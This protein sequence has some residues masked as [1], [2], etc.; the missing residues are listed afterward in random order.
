MEL[1]TFAKT[2]DGAEGSQAVEKFSCRPVGDT[3]GAAGKTQAGFTVS[4]AALPGTFCLRW[5][6][7]TNETRPMLQDKAMGLLATAINYHDEAEAADLRPASGAP[8]APMNLLLRF[9]TNSGPR[10]VVACGVSRQV[11]AEIAEVMERCG[12]HARFVDRCVPLS[13]ADR[14]MIRELH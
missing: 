4:S 6:F 7:Q 12:Q 2:H 9:E 10:T 13:V 1:P 11:A 8:D 14:L 3:E 5:V